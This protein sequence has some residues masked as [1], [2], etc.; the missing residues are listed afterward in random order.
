M[1]VK[2]NEQNQFI[3]QEFFGKITDAFRASGR[4]LQIRTIT[5]YYAHITDIAK[6][7]GR[8]L[9]LPL[10][11]EENEVGEE[12]FF[13]DANTRKIRIPEHFRT[14]GI[15]VQQD[16]L[17]EII[18][19]SVDRYFDRIDLFTK[20]IE[21]RWSLVPS[22]K[23]IPGNADSVKAVFID[24]DALAKDG[25]LVFGCPITAEMTAYKGVLSL[26]VCFYT[27]K[28]GV[29]S[30]SLNTLPISINV[31]AGLILDN[32]SCV[33]LSDEILGVLVNSSYTP[34]GAQEITNPYWSYLTWETDDKLSASHA[35]NP[36][37]GTFILKDGNGEKEY[38]FVNLDDD[39]KV[40]LE[41]SANTSI[42]G[43]DKNYE[44]AGEPISI[45]KD[46]GENGI[47]DLNDRIRAVSGEGTV[48]FKEVDYNKGYNSKINYYQ[49][50]VLDDGNLEAMNSVTP[51]TAKEVFDKK[52]A[53]DVI[54][55]SDKLYIAYT[56]LTVNEPGIY[57]VN[58][59]AFLTT[60]LDLEDGEQVELTSSSGVSESSLCLVPPAMELELGEIHL[61]DEDEEGNRISVIKN[62][63]ELT[64][65][66]IAED[67]IYVTD[68]VNEIAVKV[69]APDL[70]AVHENSN[71]GPIENYFGKVLM[72]MDYE[73]DEG[74]EEGTETLYQEALRIFG[75][76]EN[77]GIFETP[78][79][80]ETAVSERLKNANSYVSPY[81]FYEKFSGSFGD[82][83]ENIEYYILENGNMKL[84]ETILEA[85]EKFTADEQLYI[86]LAKPVL[87]DLGRA[88]IPVEDA[89]TLHGIMIHKL[90]KTYAISN[91]FKSKTITT[92]AS[93][94]I[95]ESS[96][97][98]VNE[99][100][101]FRSQFNLDGDSYL[102]EP[103][104][105]EETNVEYYEI[106]ADITAELYLT[107]E[108][109]EDTLIK[110]SNVTYIWEQYDKKD[111]KFKEIDF[112]KTN[113]N[114]KPVI[115][116]NSKIAF[117][118]DYNMAGTYRVRIRNDFNNTFKE[119]ISKNI[120]ITELELQ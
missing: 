26:S 98:K 93:T 112:T 60:M 91:I 24:S 83:V 90:N 59:Q 33:D 10:W 50:S 2:I 107:V 53:G 118:G 15:A 110:K 34:E 111:K 19:F 12:F 92:D 32:P 6:L 67:Y 119:A 120:Y 41:A 72:V 63:N 38:A 46:N 55:E 75:Y 86:K 70:P 18:Y 68:S 7:D 43:T 116:N 69:D 66:D 30:Y 117:A 62:K 97:G 42:I 113:G 109:N 76:D 20:N 104:L 77:K 28:A 101:V 23:G 80:Y 3:Y 47:A 79:L 8:F 115:A 61:I 45:F 102:M 106:S 5:E 36:K 89:I 96:N 29:R 49:K 37:N 108:F 95:I 74:S 57:Q 84:L 94:P 17:A 73:K 56:S 105:N 100:I 4:N 51:N 11:D 39:G 85:Q 99:N 114:I 25:K 88:N 27:E 65:P 52:I 81:T 78:V 16:N 87:S 48:S 13:I 40:I 58:S 82:I 22:A 21:I 31:N 64:N 44:W 1:I 54:P 103:K 9:R 14:N 71:S 35:G